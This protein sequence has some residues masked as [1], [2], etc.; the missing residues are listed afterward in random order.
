MIPRQDPDTKSEH[1]NQQPF[2][3]LAKNPL[4]RNSKS[5]YITESNKENKV[6]RN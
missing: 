2:H 3:R 4:E 5:N 6:V 1:G